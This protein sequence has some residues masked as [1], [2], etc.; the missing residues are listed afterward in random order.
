MQGAIVASRGDVCLQ[1]GET[2]GAIMNERLICA[3]VDYFGETTWEAPRHRFAH[4]V[5]VRNE[6]PGAGLWY[7]FCVCGWKAYDGAR[8]VTREDARIAAREHKR[9]PQAVGSSDG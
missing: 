4:I 6:Q 9:A 1:C 3:G 8:F 2:R 5:Y 7:A